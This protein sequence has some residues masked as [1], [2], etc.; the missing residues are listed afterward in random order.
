[1]MAAVAASAIPCW[2]FATYPVPS[3]LACF[4]ATFLAPPLAVATWLGLRYRLGRLDPISGGMLAGAL[5]TPLVLLVA[6][7]LAAMDRDSD[8]LD[9]VFEIGPLLLI[10]GV[11]LGLVAGVLVSY[12]VLLL[13]SPTRD[14]A[15]VDGV[16]GADTPEL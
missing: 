8:F 9:L 13:P 12:C 16:P 2:G 11:L 10:A 3:L 4:L 6:L 14:A 15:P 1:M 7:P 5:Q